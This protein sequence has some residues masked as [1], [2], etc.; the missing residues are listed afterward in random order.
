MVKEKR[1]LFFS[2][3]YGLNFLSARYN[4]FVF[5]K[6]QSILVLLFS[7]LNRCHLS[8]L[9]QKPIE[10]VCNRRLPFFY[11]YSLLTRKIQSVARLL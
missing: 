9:V 7:W 4:Y 3:N 2:Y 8:F 1:I 5:Y 11:Q 6:K 10:A